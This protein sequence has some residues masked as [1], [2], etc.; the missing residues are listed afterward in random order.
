MERWGRRL[1]GGLR[2]DEGRYYVTTDTMD[3]T[4][5]TNPDDIP[6]LLSAHRDVLSTVVLSRLY[7]CTHKPTGS[8]IIRTLVQLTSMDEI[9]FDECDISVEGWA[10]IGVALA[11]LSSEFDSLTHLTVS[12]HRHDKPEILLAMT[13]ALAPISDLT[14][15]RIRLPKMENDAMGV[16]ENV[17]VS[18]ERALHDRRELECFELSGSYNTLL[19]DEIVGQLVGTILDSPSTRLKSLTINQSQITLDSSVVGTVE[20]ALRNRD[21]HRH[22]NRFWCYLNSGLRSLQSLDLGHNYI[23]PI[24]FGR[25][26]DGL[27][28]NSSLEY[29]S[30][31][32]NPI[33]DEGIPTLKRLLTEHRTGC[34]TT[35]RYSLRWCRLR[36][37]HI[38]ESYQVLDRASL[39][40]IESILCG[41]PPLSEMH[42]RVNHILRDMG[43]LI[44]TSSMYVSKMKKSTLFNI[45]LSLECN[46][47]TSTTVKSKLLGRLFPRILGAVQSTTNVQF[48]L[49]VLEL[50][51]GVWKRVGA[52]D[53]I[54]SYKN[55]DFT[56]IVPN[57]TFLSM[58]NTIL[59]SFTRLDGTHS[60]L[61]MISLLNRAKVRPCRR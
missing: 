18:L 22:W 48:A 9:T 16:T 30:V 32:H 24:G 47:I 25:L 44:D 14:T 11:K 29:L 6:H 60:N 36:N 54:T 27:V 40:T 45:R 52:V 3:Y 38:A 41:D 59:K 55:D 26:A 58:T 21:L 15:L 19:K 17:F 31:M 35:V 46:R 20:E 33:N 1:P 56:N 13:M 8:L 61:L 51:G 23:S 5:R 37:G 7:L 10:L 2:I 28:F 53:R 39:R 12:C 43:P 4:R 57:S 42:S 34:L 50:V 49:K